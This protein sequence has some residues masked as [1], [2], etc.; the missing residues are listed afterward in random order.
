MTSCPFRLRRPSAR[1]RPTPEGR[2]R[3]GSCT[4][5]PRSTWPPRNA[6]AAFLTALGVGLDT[7]S[8]RGTPGRMARAY[9]EM[10]RARPFDLTTFPNDKGYDE[11]VVARSIPVQSGPRSRR[12]SADQGHQVVVHLE[13]DARNRRHVLSLV[14]SGQV[15][16]LRADADQGWQDAATRWARGGRWV[17]YDEAVAVL[18]AAVMTWAGLLAPPGEA[19][20]RARD[21][22]AVVDG[23][24]S[25]GLAHVK[26][27]RARRRTEG[28]MR[29]AITGVQAG[30]T[31][32]GT[33][34]RAARD[35]APPR[36]L[37]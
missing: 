31:G 17:V 22:A 10:F 14:G 26:A 27:R 2:P 33:R 9:A 28:W 6:A 20:T 7:E 23:F 21:L 3:C 16:S 12:V 35:R 24:G 11:L 13:G 29:E 5:Q 36:P 15:A 19:T 37:G 30:R 25:P 1:N 4:P 34:Y 8:L 18:D 32:A